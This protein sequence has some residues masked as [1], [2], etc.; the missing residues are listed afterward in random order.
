[1]NILHLLREQGIEYEETK[2]KLQKELDDEI[3]RANDR[4][5]YWEKVYAEVVAENRE[6]EVE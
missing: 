2:K 1:M 6:N 5:A 3:D 4:T